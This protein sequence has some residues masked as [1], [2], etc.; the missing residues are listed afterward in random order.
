MYATT[1][2]SIV[3]ILLSA[4]A[5]YVGWVAPRMAL[6]AWC[7]R[8]PEARLTRLVRSYSP[9]SKESRPQRPARRVNWKRLPE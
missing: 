3:S 6:V 9:L 1:G 7:K 2:P 8:H 5:M 4:V